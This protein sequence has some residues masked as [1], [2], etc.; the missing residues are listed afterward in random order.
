M[1]LSPASRLDEIGDETEGNPGEERHDSSLLLSI[2]DEAESVDPKIMLH[3]SMAVLLMLNSSSYVA[4]A[5]ACAISALAS[6]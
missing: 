4:D 6:S 3:M 5:S 1:N 2:E